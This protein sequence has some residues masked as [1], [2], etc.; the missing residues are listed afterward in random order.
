MKSNLLLLV[1]LAA[2]AWY[3]FSGQLTPPP[4]APV[5]QQAPPQP[6]VDYSKVLTYY[7]PLNDPPVPVG[8][9]SSNFTSAVVL[10]SSYPGQTVGTVN[11][12]A[13]AVSPNAGSTEQAT[14]RIGLGGA[15][16]R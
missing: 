1:L 8:T 4:P 6:T 3:L 5:V 9:G 15:G 11:G 14:S 16:N 10:G 12:T 2:A 7:S 13:T